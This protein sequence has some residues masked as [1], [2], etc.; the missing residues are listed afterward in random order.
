M[1]KIHTEKKAPT[2]ENLMVEEQL[3]KIEKNRNLEEYQESV[4][5][6]FKKNK[7]LFANRL[8]ELRHTELVKHVIKTQNTEPIKQSPYR[9]ASNEQEFL[10]SGLSKQEQSRIVLK[11]KFFKVKGNMLYKKDRQEKGNWLKVTQTFEI[12]PILFL[13]HNHSTRGHMGQTTMFEKTM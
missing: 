7:E 13:A 8:E 2:N 6:L 9:L 4:K 5:K 3:N 10:P 1:K 11:S 12:E